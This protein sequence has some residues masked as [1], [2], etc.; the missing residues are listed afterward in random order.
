MSLNKALRCSVLLATIGVSSLV[1]LGSTPRTASTRFAAPALRHAPIIIRERRNSVTTSSNWSGY[2][3][4]GSRGSV[5]DVK[6][7]WIVPAIQTPCGSTNQYASF[8]IG[9][10]GYNS[11]TVEQIGTDSDCQGG[12]PAYYA[13]YE[14]Y[15]H[16]SFGIT[17]NS[18]ILAGDVISAEVKS[19]AGGVFTVSLA[20]VTTGQSFST[21]VKMNNAQRSSAEWIAEAPWSG[22]VLPL[23]NFGT[24]QYGANYTGVAGTSS[25]TVNGVTHS[26]GAF[27]SP[28][29]PSSPVQ[30]IAMVTSGGAV[31]AQP[32]DL[33]SDGSSFGIQWLSAG[34]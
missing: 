5:T 22:G 30:E 1:G 33:S 27:G 8:W 2:A 26:I 31:K 28:T 17:L 16:W 32:S 10:D 20:D 19:T 18:P 6:G 15:P 12:A 9:I 14:F 25:A 13:W 23:A 34:P 11:N 24:A 3:V 4:T 7:S 21:S 29:A